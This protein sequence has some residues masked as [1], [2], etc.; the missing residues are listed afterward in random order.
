[1]GCDIERRRGLNIPIV[2]IVKHVAQDRSQRR[3]NPHHSCQLLRVLVHANRNSKHVLLE[4]NKKRE[5]FDSQ[6]TFE[7]T[8]FSKF[9]LADLPFPEREYLVFDASFSSPD[10]ASTV[11]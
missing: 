2:F 9:D 1:M 4:E 7:T 3:R 10:V 8:S 6:Q 5:V 11:R